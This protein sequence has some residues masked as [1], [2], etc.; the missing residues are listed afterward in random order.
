MQ[1]DKTKTFNETVGKLIK[2]I[3]H[4]NFDSL[5]KFAREYD[6]DRG[7]FSKL[8]NGI[9]CCRLITAWKFAEATGIRFSDFAKMLE[10]K[11]G[12]DFKLIDE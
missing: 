11:L 2:E 5:N 7:N 8:E 1:Q 4:N 9:V 6:F 10:Q 12:D 3:R